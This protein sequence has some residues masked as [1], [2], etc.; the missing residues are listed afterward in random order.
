MPMHKVKVIVPITGADEDAIM[1]EAAAIAETDADAVEWRFD[2]AK[3]LYDFKSWNTAGDAELYGT[4]ET[5]QDILRQLSERLRG[6]EILFTIRTG[7]QGGAFPDIQEVY[8]KLLCEAAKSGCIDLIDIEDTTA[9]FRMSKIMEISGKYKVKT[10]VSYHDFEKTPDFED[11]LSK[12]ESIRKTG[13]DIIKT[14]YM[15][16]TASDVARVLSATAYYKEHEGRNSSMITMSMGDLGKISRVS[17]AVFGSDYTFAAVGETSAP[18]QLPIKTAR[19]IMDA[20]RGHEEQ[21]LYL[22]G[23]MA[24]GKSTVAAKLKELTGKPVF[25]MDQC[26]VDKMG[27]SIAD[28][29]DKF[30]EERFREIETE[31]LKGVGD[32]K[33]AIIST[34]GGAPMRPENRDIM[35]RKG[36][37]VYLSVKPETVVKRLSVNQTE[38]PLLAGHVDIDYVKELLGK[39]D[40]VYRE[41]ADE[42]I[43]TDAMSAEEIGRAIADMMTGA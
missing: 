26:I 22:I 15:P 17:G 36:K 34:G 28:I 19:Y 11:I 16:V 32:M 43:E 13:A 18:G 20:L 42:V 29:F 8:E 6:K 2:L 23:F 33:G 41:A 3:K 1:K 10:I 39:R 30:G 21:N 40:P 7:C 37:V 27:M 24:S 4:A 25:E 12:F 5:I 9:D 14:A 31:T 38:R 35:A